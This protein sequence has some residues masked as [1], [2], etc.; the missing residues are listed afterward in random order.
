M[1]R[2]RLLRGQVGDASDTRA[3]LTHLADDTINQLLPALQQ[4]P[5]NPQAIAA[6]MR[7]LADA[8]GDRRVAA[9]AGYTSVAA[10]ELP[11]GLPYAKTAANQGASFIAGWIVQNLVGRPEP[12][13]R[14]Q[15]PEFIALVAG[16]PPAFD[17]Y[18]VAQQAAQQ[19]NVEWLQEILDAAFMPASLAA[20]YTTELQ[21]IVSS[22]HGVLAEVQSSAG[23][24]SAARTQFDEATNEA[25]DEVRSHLAE[26][27]DAAREVGVLASETSAQVQ[28]REYEERAKTVEDRANNYT[29]ASIVLGAA[30]ALASI[31]IAV[32]TFTGQQ[33]NVLVKGL[34]KAAFAVPLLVINGYL[35]SLARAFREEALRWRHISLQL[36]ATTPFLRA[37]DD[38]RRADVTALLALRFFPGQSLPSEANGG[39]SDSPQNGDALANLLAETRKAA[40][41]FVESRPGTVDLQTGKPPA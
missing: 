4:F 19:G 7:Q 24:V 21:G 18:A 2:T 27:S 39:S 22:A 6:Q 37:L 13:L 41:P 14:S 8:T 20:P 3:I 10:G 26:V 36:R 29:T 16:S 33:S 23:A 30:I 9:I 34:E 25:L 38:E 40:S 1:G 5:Q 28:A 31:G 32:L 17:Y 35:I 11:Q 15:L 12:E